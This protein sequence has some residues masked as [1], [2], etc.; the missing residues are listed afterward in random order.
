MQSGRSVKNATT[1][2]LYIVAATNYLNY[3]DISGNPTEKNNQT[4]AAL[5][6]MTYDQLLKRHLEKYREQYGRVYLDLASISSS[7]SMT[8]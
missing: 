6:G 5:K 1:A 8:S 4:M 7:T 3:H 2:T